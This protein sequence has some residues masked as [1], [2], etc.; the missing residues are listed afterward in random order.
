MGFNKDEVKGKLHEVKGQIKKSAGRAV[1]NERLQAEGG[2]EKIE[3]KVQG[4]YGK[5][6]R[7]FG[8]AIED[9]GKSIKR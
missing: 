8:E 4:G 2:A 1:G 9:I 7:K 5:G 3:G 6:K